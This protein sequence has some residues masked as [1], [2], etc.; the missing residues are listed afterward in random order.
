MQQS[1]IRCHCAVFMGQSVVLATFDAQCLTLVWVSTD[2]VR[3]QMLGLAWRGLAM[4]WPFGLHLGGNVSLI[5]DQTKG[6]LSL[7]EALQSR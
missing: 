2:L 3:M 1:S 6:V 5:Y 4:M 7:C